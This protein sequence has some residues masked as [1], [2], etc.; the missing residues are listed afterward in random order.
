M[1]IF[2]GTNNPPLDSF[3]VS[4]THFTADLEIAMKHGNIIYAFN[5]DIAPD[6]F[7]VT[8][9]QYYVSSHRIGLEHLIELKVSVT[10]TRLGEAL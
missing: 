6:I 8:R 3:L 2:H 9:E 5:L 7:Y 1:Y 4:G 10:D